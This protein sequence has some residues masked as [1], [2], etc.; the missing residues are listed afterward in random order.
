M[1]VIILDDPASHIT[2]RVLPGGGEREKMLHCLLVCKER[3]GHESGS[4][5]VPSKQEKARNPF[6]PRASRRTHCGL[7]TPGT[8][9]E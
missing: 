8:V 6:T 2:T 9:G 4:V 7:C 1:G 3:G 5:G